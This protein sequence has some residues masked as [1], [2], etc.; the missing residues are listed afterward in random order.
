MCVYACVYT[1][2]VFMY[3]CVRVNLCHARM[4]VYNVCICLRMY[5]CV[6]IGMCVCM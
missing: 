5:V 2:S 3:T 6:Y 4:C 1:F